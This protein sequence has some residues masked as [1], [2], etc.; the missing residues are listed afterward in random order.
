MS[1][2]ALVSG[3]VNAAYSGV[4]AISALPATLQ[5]LPVLALSDD[6][7][8]ALIEGNVLLRAEPGAGKSTALPLALL[9]EGN[10]AGKIILLEPR[11]IAARSV[12]ARLAFHLHEEVGQRVGLR[13]RADTRVS[14]D[15][16][17]EVVTEGVLTRL[18]Q[19]DP[20]LE[21]VALIIFDEFHERSL[22]ADI[23]LALC[24]EVQQALRDDLRLLLMSA[25]IDAQQLVASLPDIRQFHCAVRQH[26]VKTFFLGE[27]RDRIEQ[28]VL[29]A[30]VKALEEHA[31]DI[32][33]FLPGVAEINRCARVLA[34]HA[35]GTSVIIHT[36]HSGIEKAAVLRATAA[37]T[38]GCRR[39]ILSTS[40][41]ETS[42][43]IDGVCVVIDSGLERR[44]RVDR[45]T[46]A[47]LLETTVA[48]QASA[49]QRAGR[50]G[51]TAPGVCYRLWGKEGHPRRPLHWQPEILRADLAP[52]LLQLGIWGA[53]DI[54]AL[55]WLD[56][57]PQPSVMRAQQL[58]A[59]LGLW[60]DGR[61]T[62]HGREVAQVPVH[63][64]LGHMM[65]W[66][67]ARGVGEQACELAACLEGN[68]HGNSMTDIELILRQRKPS[69]VV[70]FVSQLSAMIKSHLPTGALTNAS[71]PL[72]VLLA[73]AYPD[74]IA[75][76]RAGE[77]GRFQLACGAGAVID[78][79]DPLAH[80]E[81]LVVAQLGGAGSQARIFKAIA[82]DINELE[83]HAAAH[84]D[85]VDFLDWDDDRQRVLAEK[86]RMVGS[87]LVCSQSVTTVSDSDKAIALLSAIRRQGVG[88]LPWTPRC[89]QWQA[90]VLK[91]RDLL[92]SSEL[93]GW[94]RVDDEALDA[95]LESWLLPF[96]QG[97]S[98][99]KAVQ[100]V[101]MTKALHSLLNYQQQRLLDE[102]LPPRYTVPSGSK[103]CLSYTQPGNP[104]LSV[105]LQEMLGCTTNP[106]VAKG[107]LLLTVE[108]LSPAGRPV[109]VTQDLASFWT[110]SYP[111]V[112][113]EMAGRYPKH[114]WPDDP[115]AAL[116]TTRAKPRKHSR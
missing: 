116:P 49:T 60:A 94:P 69:H 45:A 46:G 2:C 24:L 55:P 12:A 93:Q 105:R 70:R 11:R 77:P 13:M 101:D 35:E 16:Q 79:D 82:L 47:Q 37:A 23:G 78:E 50:A 40:L 39:I 109:Q 73:Q 75:K 61:I 56:Q 34:P 41:A 7:A 14:H 36:L 114:V 42:I 52:L 5:A 91:M 27:S 65:I 100:Q 106:A 81:W 99:M 15:T 80:H 96:L 22:H 59:R 32:L 57:P 53:A 92:P 71:P 8:Q 98:S 113:K 54:H 102:W 76:R 26:D 112:K 83:Q 111:A 63:P 18:L 21:G 68:Q 20:T 51:R 115:L 17:L 110:T 72:S 3:R 30:V 103:I 28:R 33:V 95:S 89:Q 43:T 44:A 64:R 19:D 25:T 97:V 31:G 104:R 108:L 9:L 38:E 86:R 10:L 4:F 1:K 62:K 84:V 6:I 48:S 88:C 87:L 107:R 74:W 58:L 90:R 85:H 29:H 67:A 66:A